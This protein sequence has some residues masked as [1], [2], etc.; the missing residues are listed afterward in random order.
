MYVRG[1]RF[2]SG[3]VNRRHVSALTRC[4]LRVGH[5]ALVAL[6]GRW[7]STPSGLLAVGWAL[8]G[9]DMCLL[10]LLQRLKTS[11]MLWAVS[12]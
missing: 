11:S 8:E 1:G 9:Q 7:L 5:G 6:L 10:S 3:D 4:W 2:S 12:I